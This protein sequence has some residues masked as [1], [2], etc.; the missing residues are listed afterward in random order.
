MNRGMIF[1]RSL[2]LLAAVA[3]AV[4]TTLMFVNP[5]RAD[6]QDKCRWDITASAAGNPA[7]CCT[8]TAN[9]PHWVCWCPPDT[10]NYCTDDKATYTTPS[11][12]YTV[13]GEGG[14]CTGKVCKTSGRHCQSI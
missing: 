3:I 8:V 13:R 6:L 9:N 4:A 10:N 11:C 2:G 7:G 5:A 14:V 1:N 12:S